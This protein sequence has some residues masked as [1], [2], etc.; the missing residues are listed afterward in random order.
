MNDRVPLLVL[1]LG[2]VLLGDDGLGAAAVARLR[3]EYDWP[4]EVSVLDGGTLGLSLLP[5]VEQ[6]DAVILVD[7][8]RADQPPGSFVRIDGDDVAP[9]VATRLS[10]HQVGV[11]DLLDGARWRERY[12]ARVVLLGLVPE[13]MELVVGLSK[14]VAPALD[15]LV[16]RIVDEAAELGFAFRP[17]SE[18]EAAAAG[19]GVDVARLVGMR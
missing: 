15:G 8:I 7:A 16:E 18:H 19:V 5:Y 3:D 10:P 11:S 12:P 17:K 4:D 13:S 14:D 1:G 9:A 6:A 2:N